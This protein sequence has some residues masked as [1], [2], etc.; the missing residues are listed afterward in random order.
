MTRLLAGATALLVLTLAGC[1]DDEPA[2]RE[3]GRPHRPEATASG[4]ATE[5]EGAGEEDETGPPCDTVDDEQLSQWAGSSQTVIGPQEGFEVHCF[6][7]IDPDD[8]LELTWR[9]EDGS[10]TLAELVELESDPSLAQRE[11]RLAGGVRAV[12]LTGDYVGSPHTRII[13]EV[14]EGLLVV[15]ARNNGIGD[16]L[17]TADEL[18]RIATRVATAYAG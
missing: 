14:E 8:S 12:M 17:R 3:A 5:G 10:D 9:F 4:S 13:A 7:R 1:S 15:D 2:D 18:R 6:S 16:V 11:V